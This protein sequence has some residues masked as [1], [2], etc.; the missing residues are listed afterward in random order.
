[1]KIAILGATSE[2][3]KDLVLSFSSWDDHD[4]VLFA[5]YP[6]KVLMWLDNVNLP[7]KYLVCEFMALKDMGSFDAILNF[8]GA[9]DPVKINE[10]GSSIF[11]VTMHYD[12]LAIDYLKLHPLCKYIFMSSGAAYGSDFTEPVHENSSGQYP[13]NNIE[14]Q[15]WYGM[16]KLFAEC[17]HRALLRLNIIDIRIFNYFSCTQNIKTGYFISDVLRAIQNKEVLQTSKENII[18]DYVGSEDFHQLIKKILLAAPVNTVVDCYSKESIDKFTLLKT[19]SEKYGLQYEISSL[20]NIIQ[21]TRKKLCY[22]SLNKR[23]T[24]FGY[25]PKYISLD[26][27]IQEMAVK[28]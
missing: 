21:P 4:L 3:A 14:P 28:L 16:A 10:M 19:L 6:K 11:D 5:R 22:Y 1:M 2:I 7:N 24:E 8:V 9:G 25:D 13:I 27:L 15:D 12:Q 18:R 23:A 26:L 17:R 20:E